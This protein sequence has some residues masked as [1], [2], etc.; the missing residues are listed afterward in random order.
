MTNAKT[1][2]GASAPSQHIMLAVRC[3]DSTVHVPFMH[4][5]LDS[6]LALAAKG[7]PLS[8]VARCGDC[9]LDDAM[10]A[11]FADFLE[12]PYT[13]LVSIDADQGWKAA[14]LVRL[15]GYDRDIVGAAILKKQDREE[16]NVQIAGDEIWSDREGLVEAHAL[17]SGMIR[18]RR[19]VIQAIWDASEEYEAPTGERKL[20]MIWHRQNRNGRRWGADYNFC[21]KAH[22]HGFKIYVDPA[23]SVD[24]IGRKVWTG[25]LADYW[26]RSQ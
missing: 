24:H 9:H 17:G 15:C 8:V 26:R 22:D 16:F 25:D 21:L 18:Y 10:N 20:R 3:Y 2:E 11:L 5:A 4:A 1:G 12:G 6:Q 19:N 14:D 7:I 13:D 23:I